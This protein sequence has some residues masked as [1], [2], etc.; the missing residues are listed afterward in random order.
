M[1]IDPDS[2]PIDLRAGVYKHYK[3]PLY[4][5]MGYSH[6]ASDENR[7]QVLYIELEID[8]KKPGP[9][10]ATRDWR[11]F[12][13]FICPIHDGVDAYSAVHGSILNDEF[14][15]EGVMPCKPTD[16]LD[17]FTYMGPI[18]YKGFEL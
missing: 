1:V 3:G 10:F 15:Y 7:I 8:P 14:V 5:V 11:E 13:A 2:D 12:F 9:R 17:R 18:Y 16:Y 6:N 4:Q